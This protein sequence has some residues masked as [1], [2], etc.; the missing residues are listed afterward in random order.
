MGLGSRGVMSSLHHQSV[1]IVSRSHYTTRILPYIIDSLAHPLPPPERGRSARSAGRGS[2]MSPEMPEMADAI[3]VFL[4]P[5]GCQPPPPAGG[6][7]QP[8]PERL[9]CRRHALASTNGNVREGGKTPFP[10]QKWPGQ[11]HEHSGRGRE[12]TTG[13]GATTSPLVMPAHAGI[14]TMYPQAHEREETCYGSPLSQG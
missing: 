1:A 2:G 9:F 5:C 8:P 12:T 3:V 13:Q 11:W 6:G 7:L 14:H 4:Q 10:Q